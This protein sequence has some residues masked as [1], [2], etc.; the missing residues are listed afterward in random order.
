MSA[1]QPQ[2]WAGVAAG[3]RDS[4]LCRRGR[5]STC[6]EKIR[7]DETVP[8]RPA[9]D[10]RPAKAAGE[11]CRGP[12]SPRAKPSIYSLRLNGFFFFFC[13]LKFQLFCNFLENVRALLVCGDKWSSLN[14][15]PKVCH[16]LLT[17]L[18]GRRDRRPPCPQGIGVNI[19]FPSRDPEETRVRPDRLSVCCGE[20]GTRP[21]LSLTAARREAR[22]RSHEHPQAAGVRAQAASAADAHGPVLPP[23]AGALLPQAPR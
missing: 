15:S 9:A 1:P 20:L 2:H 3:G 5:Q 23:G 14:S 19:P 22:W 11:P 8:A 6:Q 18:R 17:F 10:P 13:Y 12:R 4:G 21:A 16:V 7:E